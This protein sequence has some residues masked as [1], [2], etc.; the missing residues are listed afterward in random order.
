MVAGDTEREQ[1]S[2]MDVTKCYDVSTFEMH[3]HNSERARKVDLKCW[4][5]L[6]CLG[7]TCD[8]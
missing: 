1:E 5:M 4:V 3:I 6:I 8:S 7:T 2:K